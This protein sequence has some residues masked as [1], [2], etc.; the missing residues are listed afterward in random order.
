MIKQIRQAAWA[1]M[2]AALLLQV[3]PQAHAEG[4]MESIANYADQGIE[5]NGLLEAGGYVIVSSLAVLPN[6][7]LL[8]ITMARQDHAASLG[9]TCAGKFAIIGRLSADHGRTWGPAFTVL[10]APAD[11]SLT[12]G[13]PSLVVAGD[14]V[15]AIATMSTP[16]VAAFGYGGTRLLQATSADHGRTWSAP[17]EIVVPR[18]RAAVSGRIG[19]TLADGTI[20]LPYWWDFMFQTEALGMAQ[21]GDIPAVSG[22]LI[23]S[24]GGAT[25]T[26]S[27]DVYG[28][29]SATPKILRTA[30]EPAIVALSGATVFMVLRSTREDGA[31]EETW[32]RDGGRTW[33][34]TR[35]GPLTSFNTPSC[36]YRLRRGAVVRLWDNSRTPLRF[37]LVAAISQDEC[38][39]WSAPRT[40]VDFPAGSTWPTQASYP[41]VVETADGALV[42][43]WCQVTPAG[44]WVLVSGRFTVDWVLARQ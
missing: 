12:A 24:D 35:P 43:V 5:I 3:L 21:I 29:W 15:I 36:L 26:P 22:T 10:D 20:L 19:V 27:T 38:R 40:L 33:E 13:D 8:C 25:W 31:A 41:S 6:G 32:S 14:K 7:D 34:Q 17:V 42:A 39:T 30:D 23:S 28:Q 37:P 44:K 2:L 4:T 9:V 18:A 11:G 1:G 16:T